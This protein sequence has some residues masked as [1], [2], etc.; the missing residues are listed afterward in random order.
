MADRLDGARLKL[1]RANEH[2]DALEAE[3]G[4]YLAGDFY[5]LVRDEKPDRT[6]F[7]L[8]VKE[9]PP[10]RLSVILGDCVHN[11]R[12]SLDYVAWQLVI[13]NG[14]VPDD[15]TAFPI[16]DR[17]PRD[18]VFAPKSC[19]G[20]SKDALALIEG[21]QPYQ[22]GDRARQH[23]LWFVREL[24][25]TD[26]H[27][28]LN[29]TAASVSGMNVRLFVG[30]REHTAIIPGGIFRHRAE[31]ASF[32]IPADVMERD[33]VKVESRGDSF[34][35]LKD[36]GPWGEEPILRLL[37]QAYRLIRFGLLPQIE[38]LPEMQ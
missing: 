36:V 6:I 2:L 5:M 35:A 9:E 3:I 26:K 20:M 34:I 27:R 18:G 8:W 31:V 38:A 33:Y 32:P 29:L 13:A 21:M 37:E 22:A 10:P 15:N 14:G 28:T 12:S 4:R 19:A 23:V 16:W 11:L 7:H 17:K 25:N 1:E 30:S 24:S